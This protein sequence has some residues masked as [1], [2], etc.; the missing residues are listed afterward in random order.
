MANLYK[1]SIYD[2]KILEKQL[3]DITV[4]CPIILNDNNILLGDAGYDSNKLREKV[5]DIK[6]GMLLT[7]KNK[8]NIICAQ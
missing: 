6:L 3:D 1:G 4:N 5:K 2:S 7:N 8:R